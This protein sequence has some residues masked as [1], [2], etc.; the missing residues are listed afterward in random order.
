[1]RSASVLLALLTAS[2]LPLSGVVQAQEASAPETLR[3]LEDPEGDSAIT[4]AGQS[5]GQDRWAATDL[6]SLDV[7]ETA[8]GLVITLAVRGLGGEETQIVDDAFYSIDLVAKDAPYRIEAYYAADTKEAFASWC[9]PSDGPFYRCFEE[10]PVVQDAGAGTLAF[11]VASALLVAL[12]GSPMLRGDAVSAF[13]AD[14][15]S[16]GASVVAGYTLG[17]VQSYD[18]MPDTGTSTTSWI[19]QNGVEQTGHLVL[20]AKAPVRVTNGEATTFLFEL[21]LRNTLDRR[22]TAAFSATGAPSTWVITFPQE[23][24]RIE[25]G[26][27]RDVPVLVTIPFGHQH[28]AFLPFNVT[29]QSRSDPLA[30][31][32]VQLGVRYTRVPQPAGHH[33]MLYLHGQDGN[34]YL[35]TLEEEEIPADENTGG[36]V[37]GGCGFSGGS[38]SGSSTLVS[39]VPQLQIGIDAAMD[40]V[41]VATLVLQSDVPVL[42]S[43][44]VGGYFVTWDKD[45]YPETCVYEAPE[46]AVAAI[47]RSGPLTMEANTPLVVDLPIRPLPYGDRVEYDPELR[48][49]L[50]LVVYQEQ[51]SSPIC[52]LD[53]G[54]P[55]F[56][57][58]SS[59]QLPL[60]EYH[61]PVD[62]YFST[63]SG[64]DLTALTEQQ[65]LVNVGETAIFRVE[66]QNLGT[67]AA[68]FD[69]ELTGVNTQW[70]NILGDGRITIPAGS[71]RELA[72]AVAVPADAHNA[73]LADITL[74]AVKSDDENVRSLIRLLATVDTTVDHPDEADQAAGLDASLTGKEAPGLPLA[75]LALALLALVGRRR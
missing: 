20:G 63:L 18:A 40:A 7:S 26:E 31:G 5:S 23:E 43:A 38:V 52:C 42:E 17:Q 61:D 65:R 30:A 8:T 33:N 13:R 50:V 59:F 36:R 70:A 39:L 32:H 57:A 35:N 34:F 67:K 66:A 25:G 48:F 37:G 72:V 14:A 58:G 1:M 41:G 29:A 16:T 56:V 75:L 21:T 3:V 27:E 54:T 15:Q 53:V 73:D 24:V 9:A 68:T 71:I 46:Q 6:R 45:E 69:L 60:D 4:V 51:G 55:S 28:G 44:S 47:E 22:D 11:N 2:L 74:H 10:V 12:D 62:E 64:I 19:I 49:G